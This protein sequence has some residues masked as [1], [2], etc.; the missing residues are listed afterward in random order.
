MTAIKPSPPSRRSTQQR[1]LVV[2]DEASIRDL[3][4]T[5]L[6]F[7]GFEVA[8]AADGMRGL[9][10]VADFAPDLVL[11]DISMPGLDGLEVCRRMRA[12][13]HLHARHLP[14]RPRRHR[15]HRHRVRR[16]R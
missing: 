13:R 3:V 9:A 7:V 2:D 1:I 5:A 16:R 10:A 11:L 15:R 6:E 8:A 12:E 14:H 4:T